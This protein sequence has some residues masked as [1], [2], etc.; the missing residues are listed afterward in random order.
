M[1][2]SKPI[3]L[4]VIMCECYVCLLL[5]TDFS[6][7]TKN[8][9]C[10]MC[11]NMYHR[12]VHYKNTGICCASWLCLQDDTGGYE[13]ELDTKPSLKLVKQGDLYITCGYGSEKDTISYKFI[14]EDINKWL[15]LD[16]KNPICDFCIDNMIKSKEIHYACS[17]FDFV[18]N[19]PKYCDRCGT[20]Y[21]KD[22]CDFMIDAYCDEIIIMG[23][24]ECD[25]QSQLI[26]YIY[27]NQNTQPDWLKRKNFVCNLCVST[28]LISNSI[29][30]KT[31]KPIIDEQL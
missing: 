10:A 24:I 19:Y 4:I 15:S 16:R 23:I 7:L 9:N 12:M 22:G 1:M 8:I 3:L 2:A 27:P 18:I 28:L 31:P 26:K 20:F 29:L 25:N 13:G 21:E 14:C 11:H 30:L 6:R 17:A 5:K